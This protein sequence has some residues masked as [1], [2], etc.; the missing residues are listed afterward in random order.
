MEEKELKLMQM[1]IDNL[2][3]RIELY[4]NLPWWKKLFARI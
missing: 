4:N 1:R 3:A 2:L